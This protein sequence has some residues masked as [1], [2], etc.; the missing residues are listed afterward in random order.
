MRFIITIVKLELWWGAYCVK[1]L[2]EVVGDED[3][4]LRGYTLSWVSV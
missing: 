2:G 4:L 3:L 1:W